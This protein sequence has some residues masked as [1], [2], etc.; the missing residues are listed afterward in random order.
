MMVNKKEQISRLGADS[1][2]RNIIADYSDFGSQVFAPLTKLGVFPDRC[3][4]KY[5]VKSHLLHTYRGTTL[6]SNVLQ[7][8]VCRCLCCYNKQCGRL[9]RPTRYAPPR[10]P[11][12]LIFDRLTLKLLCE[13]HLRWGTFFPNLG[14]LGL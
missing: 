13:S 1:H 8:V 2:G 7:Y 10:P 14:T 11:P 4:S 9:V 12:T 3:Q 5:N 6:T